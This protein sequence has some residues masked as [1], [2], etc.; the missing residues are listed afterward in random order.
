MDDDLSPLSACGGQDQ[1]RRAVAL[2]VVPLAAG[3]APHLQQ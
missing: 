2:L 1:A 3:V